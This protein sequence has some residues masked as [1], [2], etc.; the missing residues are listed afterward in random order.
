MSHSELWPNVW[1]KEMNRDNQITQL[2]KGLKCRVLAAISRTEP[3]FITC[4]YLQYSV[5]LFCDLAAP[6]NSTQSWLV[7]HWSGHIACSSVERR[8][9]LNAGDD[10]ASWW[11]V[12]SWK[13]TSV[14]LTL[15][16]WDILS[17]HDEVILK[18]DDTQRSHWPFY[19]IK[20]KIASCEMYDSYLTA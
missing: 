14:S 2:W 15:S 11:A 7:D 10:W 12:V 8:S 17:L 4:L 13:A 19:V 18:I 16:V 3:H 1:E 9:S 20:C 5:L 6:C